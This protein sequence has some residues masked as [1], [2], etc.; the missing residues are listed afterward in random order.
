MM[1]IDVA[2]EATYANTMAVSRSRAEP[3]GPG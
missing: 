2:T 1:A 3:G